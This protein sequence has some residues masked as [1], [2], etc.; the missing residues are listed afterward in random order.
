MKKTS[1]GLLALTLVLLAVSCKNKEQSETD[2]L[3]TGADSVAITDESTLFFADEVEVDEADIPAP[4]DNE[5]VLRFNPPKGVTYSTKMKTVTNIRQSMFDE[6]SSSVMDIATNNR[7]KVLDNIPGQSITLSSTVSYFKA[8]MKQDTMTAG[9]ESGK[10]STDPEIDMMRQILDCYINMPIDITMNRNAE[11]IGIK[12]IEAVQGKIAEKLGNE[13]VTAS[14]QMSDMNQEV[15]NSFVAFPPKPVANGDTWATVDSVDMGGF[16][17]IMRN[18]FTL[19]R[20]DDKYAWVDVYSNFS[21]DKE[22]LRQLGGSGDEVTMTGYQKGTMK[23]ERESGWS[24]E[25]SLEQKLNLSMD[26]QGQKMSI[27]I[28]GTSTLTTTR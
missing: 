16:P 17:T 25:S 6:S 15:V 8:M 3:I 28:T 20:Y 26:A 22:M 23:V 27:S 12:G 11:V 19:Q 7:I 24:M 4:K 9:F 10:P 21:I 14:M 13:A 2:N 1:L 18:T 5:I